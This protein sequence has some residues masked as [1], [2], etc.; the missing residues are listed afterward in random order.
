MKLHS[1][2]IGDSGK[3]LL[4]VHG[5]F[6]MGDNWKS[7]GRRFE[8]EGGFQVHLIDQR[9]HGRSPH[10]DDFSY[11]LMAEDLIEYCEENDLK[12]VV[13]IGHSMGGKVAMQLAADR[14]ELIEAL[15]VVDIA[16]K[17]YPPHHDEILQGLSALHEADLDSRTKADE[18]LEPFVSSWSVRQFLLKNLYWKEKGKLAL[19]MNLPILKQKY[20]EVTGGIS[21]NA[22]YEG[23]TFFIKG[24]N[25]GYIQPE[26]RPLLNK[27]FPKSQLLTL[28]EAGHWVHAEKPEEF[29]QAVMGFL[30]HN[31]ICK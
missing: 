27:H 12:K 20:E 1:N 28:K 14:P 29:F 3:P 6:G 22:L 9:N 24:D 10:S 11:E 15:I 2:I 5:L 16:P 31:K 18:V 8:G 17:S 30:R 7:L 19:R 13:V 25:S 26:D 4:I 23:P 21:E